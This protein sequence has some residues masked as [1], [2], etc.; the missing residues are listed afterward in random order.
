MVLDMVY[1]IQDWADTKL[2]TSTNLV[3]SEAGRR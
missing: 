1:G 3:E 2:L